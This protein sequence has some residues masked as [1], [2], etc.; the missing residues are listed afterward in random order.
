VRIALAFVLVYTL[1]SPFVSLVHAQNGPALPPPA[2]LTTTEADADG[3]GIPDRVETVLG[4]PKDRADTLYLVHHDKAIAEGDPVHSRRKLVPDITDTYFGNVAGNRWVWRVDF[5]SKVENVGANLLFYMDVDN[6]PTTGRQGGATGTDVRMNCFDGSPG[7]V[8]RNANVCSRDRSMRSVAV[9]NSIYYCMDL[10]VHTAANGLAHFRGRLL[11]QMAND[12]ADSDYA[13]WFEIIGPKQQDVPKPPAGIASQAFSENAI[14]QKPWHGWRDDLRRGEPVMLV[15]EDA[16]TTGMKA[17]NK[18]FEPVAA[19]ASVSW[20]SPVAGAYHLSVLIQDS[21]VGK[22]EVA[23][24]VDGNAIARSVAAQNDGDLYLFTTAKPVQF[25]QGSN[26]VLTAA[27]PAQ[28]FRLCEFFLTSEPVRPGPLAIAHLETFCPAQTGD[29]VNI[30]ICF[31]TNFPCD[32]VV[33]WG[34]GDALTQETKGDRVTY[35]HRVRLASLT[36]GAAYSLQVTVRD[37]AETVASDVLRFV[38]DVRRPDRCGVRSA[39]VS[40]NL[41]DLAEGR[42]GPWPLTGGIPLQEGH[43]ADTAHCRLKDASGTVAM[44]QFDALA[45]WPDGSIKWLFVTH[46]GEPTEAGFSL[47]YGSAVTA[48]KPPVDAIRVEDSGDVLM[49]TTDC[50]RTT[51]SRTRF[52]PPGSVS[53]DRNGDGVFSA[54]ECVVPDDGEGLVLTDAKG[55]R[56]T[57]TGAVPTRL[58]VEESGPIR[59]VILAEGPLQG[60]AD[61]LLSYRC[62][63]TFY[64][65][66]R[67]IPTVVSL[68]TDQGTTIF[69]PTMHRIRSF[70]LSIPVA[71]GA[72]G[73]VERRVQD[74]DYHYAVHSG[75]NVVEHKGTAS[76]VLTAT[77]PAGSVSAVVK[78]FWQLFPKGL[79]FDGNR[80]MVELFP[81][82][83]RDRYAHVKDAKQLTMNYYWFRDGA[84]LV[85]CGNAPSTDILFTFDVPG[86]TPPAELGA[87]WQH[88][89]QL[90]CSPEHMCAS[91]AFM[92][93]EPEQEG[94]LEDYQ[95]FVRDGFEK[96]EANREHQRWYSWMNYGDWYGERGVNWGNQEYDMQFGLLLHYARSGDMRFLERAETA[97]RH[98]ACIDQITWSPVPARMGIQKEHAL[99]HTG[100]FNTPKIEGARFWFA[101]GIYNT[102]HMWTQGTYAAYCLTGDR[103]FKYAMDCLS[104]WMAGHYCTYL[105]RW[106]HRNYGWATMVVLGAWQVEPNPYYLNAAR[107]FMKNVVSK[108]DPG[109]GTFIHNIGECTHQPRHMGGKTFMSGVVTTALKM[110]D[111]IEPN[112]DYKEALIGTCDWMQARM[113]YPDANGFQYAQCTQFDN[114]PGTA[115]INMACEGLAYAYDL[116]NKPVYRDM[117]VRSLARL[118]RP[119]GGS[120]S[121][122]GYAQQIR[123]TPFA[124]SSMAR[125]GM[126]ALP[127]VPSR[128]PAGFVPE[129]LTLYGGAPATLPILVDNESRATYSCSAEITSVSEGLTVEP[130]RFEWKAASGATL[131]SPF[132]VTGPGTE[133]ASVTIAYTVGKASGKSVC[134]IRRGKVFTLGTKVGYVGAPEDPVGKALVKMGST[135][136]R[137][138]KLSG[139]ALRG[140]GALLVGSEAHEKGFGGLP[141]TAGVLLDFVHSGGQI[142]MM[143]I[144][145]SSFR[146]PYLPF[147]LAVS[148]TKRALGKIR[149]PTHPLFSTPNTIR[150]LAGVVSYDTLTI[151]DRAWTV[152]AE[153]TAGNPAIV[154]AAFGKGR[155]LLVQ[156]SPDRYVIGTEIPGKAF[157]A[158]TCRQ[159]FEN[160]LAYLEAHVAATA[161]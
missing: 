58:V 48:P 43:L 21:K 2:K 104:E 146:T 112:D 116:T 61:R 125:W 84:Y 113:W 35:N 24:R 15:A 109:T 101:N 147:P 150:S 130:R 38:A 37:G 102:G 94:I 75:G 44:A 85:P 142:V 34:A 88:A 138:S 13:D 46:V 45:R 157:T 160:I 99:W 23:V 7:L 47:E 153:D 148:N 133:G 98:T 59:T 110:M 55:K 67:G 49:V 115:G 3:D 40:L 119:N 65:G 82:L 120:G 145:N 90:A 154:E 71:S 17:F 149:T 77:T 29:G 97:A 107:L 26:I 111:Q 73:P 66:F 70:T 128:A 100:G 86:T 27:T 52:T 123:M 132:V 19:N 64:R 1:A 108:R 9:G 4:M 68:V 62:R 78:D 137:V 140:Y 106:L 56:Y 28:D 124:F 63:M 83:P 31:L 117:V 156:P 114:R 79:A 33:R 87:A 30:D 122:K 129:E 96:V 25:K 22:E 18:A 134:K 8:V 155:V 144:Q 50:L 136:E 95:G 143:Q 161:N 89:A 76:P 159:F 158:D 91:G 141:G 80:L 74:D 105:E 10:N 36:R 131:N 69:P 54:D 16:E 118:V 11:C 127:V 14:V 93:L 152:L 5:A 53:L 135:V 103:R 32:A 72:A 41:A 42:P 151:A 20:S 81:E 6:D 60:E 39:S 139:A 92:D 57:S 51:L 126:T 121:G 12:S